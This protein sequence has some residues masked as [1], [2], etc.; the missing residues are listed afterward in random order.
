MRVDARAT[1]RAL[2]RA[3]DGM[4]FG[5]FT[6]L[7]RARARTR[8][9]ATTTTELAGVGC[10]RRTVSWCSTDDDPLGGAHA[11]RAPRGVKSASCA[12]RSVVRL[13]NAC[14][15]ATGA[16]CGW[17][18]RARD[19]TRGDETDDGSSIVRAQD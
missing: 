8:A 16:T 13:V 9:R 6:A 14:V 18:R 4:F 17:E 2:A 7:L 1:L 15:R 10:G 5:I 19:E 11:T 3:L 12:R